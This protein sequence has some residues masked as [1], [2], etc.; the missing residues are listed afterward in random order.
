MTR[1]KIA[2][3]LLAILI[4]AAIALFYAPMLFGIAHLGDPVMPESRD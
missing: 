1:R 4:A 3:W 2:T